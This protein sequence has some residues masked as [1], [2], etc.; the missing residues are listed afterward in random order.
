MLLM[1]SSIICGF[2]GG[3]EGSSKS[4]LKVGTS[5]KSADS[6]ADK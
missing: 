2:R 5:S 1:V 4:P 6:E 3:S